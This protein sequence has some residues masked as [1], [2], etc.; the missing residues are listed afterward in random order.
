MVRPL[1]RHAHI[2]LAPL[3]AAAH[4][5]RERALLPRLAAAEQA[6]YRAFSADTR[7]RTWLAGREL[8]LAALAHAQGDA[9]PELLLTAEHGGLRYGE[10][11]VHL[12]LSHS[13]EWLAAA[14]APVPVGIDIEQLRLRAVTGQAAKV[15]CPREA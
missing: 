9:D 1:S 10:G 6:R 3:D 5:D 4:A 8:L 11:H 13:G 14:V 15:F 7:R 2:H 12:N